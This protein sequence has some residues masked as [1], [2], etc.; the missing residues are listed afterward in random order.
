MRAR[1]IER[2]KQGELTR[3]GISRSASDHGFGRGSS[4]LLCV[5][6]GAQVLMRRVSFIRDKSDPSILQIHVDGERAGEARIEIPRVEGE[7]VRVESVRL[8]AQFQG[9]PTL[10]ALVRE[11]LQYFLGKVM[12]AREVIFPE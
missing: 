8:E 10:E 4:G 7:P 9:D 1:F 12:G 11:K 3:L 6:L 2:L 5:Y